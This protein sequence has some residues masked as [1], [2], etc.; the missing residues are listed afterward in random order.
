MKWIRS[1]RLYTAAPINRRKDIEMNRAQDSYEASFDT[2]GEMF[3]Y[4][5]ALNQ[6]S[7]WLKQDVKSLLVSPLDE[8]SPLYTSRALF[9][10]RVSDRAIDDTAQNTGLALRVD[11][12]VFPLRDTA[13]K[14]LLDRAKINGT[15]LPKLSKNRLADTL[16]SCLQV[17]N[18]AQALVL[19]R[20]EKVT[21]VHSGD[22]R[23][24]SRLPIHELLSSLYDMLD[25]RF[26]FAEFTGGYSN[27]AMAAATFELPGQT[28]ELLETYLLALDAIGST[29]LAER[30]RPAIRFQSSDVGLSAARVSAFLAGYPT[31]I[32]VGSVIAVEHRREASVSDFRKELDRIYAQYQDQIIKLAKLT[33]VHLHYPVNAMIAACKKL[34]LPK[35]AALEA[36]SMF[37]ISWGGNAGTAHDVFMALQEIMYILKNDNFS[38]R[39]LFET[40][41]KLA[42]AVS[43]H[44][45]SYDTA[46]AVRY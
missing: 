24:Y 25:D 31:P 16:N 32:P 10:S 14:S 19:I 8:K 3:S 29:K 37:E 6:D 17:H 7:L 45:S 23:D 41:E 4:H 44:W 26:P 27:H 9:D 30:L 2:F 15:A 20:D 22:Q 1:G 12:Q 43:L 5:S 33:E 11:G 38:Q 40:E 35:K 18:K 36:I 39:K 34:S 46:K 28:E 21:A 13:Y 42:G